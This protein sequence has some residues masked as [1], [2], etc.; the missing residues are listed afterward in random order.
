L[1]RTNGPLEYD[2]FEWR[3]AWRDKA[4]DLKLRSHGLTVLR[5]NWDLVHAQPRA[6]YQDLMRTLDVRK[7]RAR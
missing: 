5:Y 4:N 2:F 3:E 6:V 7:A 1:A